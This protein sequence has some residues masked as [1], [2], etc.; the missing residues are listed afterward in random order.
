[1]PLTSKQR[2][3]L[4]AKAKEKGVDAAKL[5]A[6]AEALSADGD[7]PGIDGDPKTPGAAAKG[8]KPNLYMYHL[9]FVTVNE[10]REIW[11]DLDPVTGGDEYAGIWAAKQ[12]GSTK[13]DPEAA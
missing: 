2:T 10:V 5:I 4:E 8:E 7:K 9:P 3:A 1:M 12:G 13:P 11:L 6:A